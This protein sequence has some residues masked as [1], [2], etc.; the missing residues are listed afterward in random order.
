[1]KQIYQNKLQGTTSL[2]ET[3]TLRSQLLSMSLYFW[4]YEFDCY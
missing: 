1:M 3:G 4:C 2:T